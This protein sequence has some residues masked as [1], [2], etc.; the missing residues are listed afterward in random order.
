MTQQEK[1]QQLERILRMAPVIPVLTIEDAASAVALATAL[2]AG[3]AII[4]EVTLRTSAGLDAIRR[5]AAECAKVIVGVG[6]VTS[7]RELA[8]AEE[9]GAAFA[10][11]P[12]ATDTIL[13]AAESSRIPLL[14]GV[15]TVSEAMRLAERGYRHLKLF[16]ANVAGGASFLQAVHAPLP[17]LRFCPT[18]GVSP[19]NLAE[20]L[21]LSNVCCVGGS[22]LATRQLIAAA[23]WEEIT[24]NAQEAGRI[25]SSI[26]RKTT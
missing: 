19:A 6:T 20:Y 11:S 16:P 10:V 25:A 7:P 8:D 2:A 14:P 15:M 5:I 12:G 13:S 17:Q 21:S 23:R 24:R 22:W 3:G 1:Q 9:A 4:L 18:G 26:Q